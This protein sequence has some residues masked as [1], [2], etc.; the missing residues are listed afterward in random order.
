MAL[1]LLQHWLAC[2][3]VSVAFNLNF[4]NIEQLRNF[5]YFSILN[6]LLLLVSWSKRRAETFIDLHLVL[7]LMILILGRLFN[8][9]N[10]VSNPRQENL[11]ELTQV[12]FISNLVLVAVIVNYRIENWCGIN[13]RFVTNRDQSEHF[14]KFSY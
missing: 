4:F 8:C 10:S 9:V 11:I 3:V 5:I 14:F 12:T 7:W 6:H 13:I 2:L 1:C